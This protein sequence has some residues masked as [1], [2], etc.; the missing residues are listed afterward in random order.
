VNN[1]LFDELS[2]WLARGAG[3]AEPAQRMIETS[4]ARV[5]LFKDRALKLKKPVDFGFLDFTTPERR[6]WAMERELAFNAETAPDLY[7]RVAPI[8]RGA[9][10]GL[11]LGGDG[12]PVDWVLEMRRFADDAL[13][14]GRPEASDGA[15]LEGLGREIARFHAQA[16][17]GPDGAG[18]DGID[19]VLASNADLLGRKAGA[20]GSS[21][22]ARLEEASRAEFARLEP[23]L[24]ARG[25]QGFV[26]RCHGDLHLGNI[27]VE[28]GR[29]VLFDCVEFN[30]TLSRIDVLYDLGF[31]L[32]DLDFA[33]RRPAANRALNGWLDEAARGLPAEGFWPGLAALPLF[34]SVRAAVRAHVTVNQGE[35][36][37]ARRYVDAA[38]AHLSPPAPKLVA[39]GGYSGSGKTT[40]AR[41]LAPD[42]GPAPGAVVLR[43]DEVRK[44]LWGVGPLDRLPPESYAPGQS[45]RVYGEMNAA[46]R[47]ALA[48]GRAVVLD[49]AFLRPEERGAAEALARQAGVDFEGLWL[50]APPAVLRARV[51]ARIGDA[52]DADVAVLDR[53]LA[54]DVGE[55]RW[56]RP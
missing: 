14:A 13:L 40:A 43:S 35:V 30:D 1:R 15:F 49:A 53:Q 28:H 16:Q 2:G 45:E 26:R 34:Q 9:D 54:I 20:L 11:V 50:E 18:R 4:I 19:Y 21:A 55:V 31:L 29:P 51:A 8:T 37:L 24:A 17:R 6:R 42:L 7:R 56:R 41:D 27:M 52:S 25:V 36:E 10:G 32:M 12:E 3:A 46:A 33:G 23:M 5:F 47:Q 22:L 38:L 48:A 39:V 44:R